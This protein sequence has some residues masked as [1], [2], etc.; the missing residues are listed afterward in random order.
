MRLLTTPHHPGREHGHRSTHTPDYTPAL[1]PQEGPVPDV[2]T[3]WATRTSPDPAG[4]HRGVPARRLLGDPLRGVSGRL[5][6]PTHLPH[7]ARRRAAPRPLRRPRPT[8]G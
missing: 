8:T 4:P 6:L 1:R 7:H 3:P 5:L 2:W